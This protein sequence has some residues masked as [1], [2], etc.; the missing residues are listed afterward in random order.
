MKGKKVALLTLQHFANAPRAQKEAG[1]LARAGADVTVFGSW[2]SD[3][4]AQEDLALAERLGITYI[5]LIDLRNSP[6][7][8]RIK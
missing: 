7:G 6:L 3:E 8:L 4:R 2:W 1:S 5:P